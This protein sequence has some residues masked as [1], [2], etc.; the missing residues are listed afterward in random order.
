VLPVRRPKETEGGHEEAGDCAA[1]AGGW[2]G[3]VTLVEDAAVVPDEANDAGVVG[4]AGVPDQRAVPEHPHRRRRRHA[5][6]DAPLPLPLRVSPLP[7]VESRLVSGLLVDGGGAHPVVPLLL[8]CGGWCVR[9]QHAANREADDSL[10]V[11][12]VRFFVAFSFW[13]MAERDKWL[14]MNF[15]CYVCELS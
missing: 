3:G 1:P 6:P 8:C 10:L 13:A 15:C 14:A 5:C 7:P 9:E 11:I 2:V 4:E 12:F